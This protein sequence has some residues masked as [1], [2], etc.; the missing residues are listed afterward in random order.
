MRILV[1][2]HDGY[3]GTRLVPLLQGAGHTVVGLDSALYRSC[4]VDGEPEPVEELLLDVRDVEPHHLEGFDAVIHL[5]AISND[6]LG[7]LAP[8]TT[9]DVNWRG[10]MTLAHA[11]KAAGVPRFAFSSSCSIYGAHG[12]DWI[13]ES[14]ELRPVTPYGESKI[15]AERDLA[16]MADDDFSPVFLRN[17]TAYGLSPRLRG[18]LVVNN[19]VGYAVAIGEVRLKSDGTPWRPLVHVEDISRAFL[20]LVEAPADRV[21]CEAFNVGGTAENYRIRDV[22]SIVEQTVPGSRVTFGEG[23]GPDVRNY[24]VSCDKLATAFPDAVPSWDVRRGAEEVYL[25]FARTG[26]TEDELTGPRYQR[27]QRIQQLQAAGLLDAL[28]TRAGAGHHAGS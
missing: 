25:A 7:D 11:A 4:S 27:L 3:I 1:T 10:T 22:A 16:A 19:L 20:A 14:G 28:L 23:A 24:R 5:A 26:L 2:G 6:P 17:A 12:D 13:D 9:Y 8:D 18:D 15:F 21:H